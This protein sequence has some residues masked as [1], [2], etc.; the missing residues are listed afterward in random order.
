MTPPHRGSYSKTAYSQP[1]DAV[2]EQGVGE[3]NEQNCFEIP[4]MRVRVLQAITP[5][6]LARIIGTVTEK[7]WISRPF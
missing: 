4:R 5:I 3:V 7:W 2:F 6:C 1:V